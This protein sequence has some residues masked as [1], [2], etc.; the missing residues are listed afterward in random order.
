[1][2]N[3]IPFPTYRP[4]QPSRARKLVAATWPKK[5]RKHSLRL[6]REWARIDREDRAMNAPWTSAVN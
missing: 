2:T 4:P 5:P 3:V 6:L 1:M